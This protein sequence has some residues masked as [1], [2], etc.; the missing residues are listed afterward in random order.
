MPCKM[1]KITKSQGKLRKCHIVYCQCGCCNHCH[2]GGVKNKHWFDTKV[3]VPFIKGQSHGGLGWIPK[4][5]N[6]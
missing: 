1:C 3:F 4:C 5:N 6:H 2:I